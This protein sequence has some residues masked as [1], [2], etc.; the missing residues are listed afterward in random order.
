MKAYLDELEQSSEKQTINRKCY[1]KTSTRDTQDALPNNETQ[2]QVLEL[3]FKKFHAVV[4][5]LAKRRE[6]RA[7]LQINDEYG[8]Q[9]LLRSLMTNIL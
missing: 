2:L 9:Y 3:L 5:S 7:P 1:D 8:V 4:K 6:N